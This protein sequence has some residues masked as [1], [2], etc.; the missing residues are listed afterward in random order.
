M[1]AAITTT[2]A[3]LPRAKAREQATSRA[4]KA[5]S[6]CPRMTSIRSVKSPSCYFYVVEGSDSKV[7]TTKSY[8]P[9]SYMRN[10]QNVT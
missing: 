9:S 8:C 2:G 7:T 5:Q 6:P 3:S 10:F 1:V 4:G